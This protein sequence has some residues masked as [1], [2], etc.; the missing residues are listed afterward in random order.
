MVGISSSGDYI[1]MVHSRLIRNCPITP[2]AVN[3]ANT[4]FGPD[5]A[6][7]KGKTTRKYYKPV[8]TDHVEIP[9]HIL[10][11]ENAVTLEA[12]MMFVNGMGFFVGTSRKI[13]FTTHG[14]IPI[15]T[16]GKLGNSLRKVISLYNN[17]LFKIRNALMDREFNCLIPDFQ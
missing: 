15:C 5:I 8:V 1:N 17:S 3:I 14:Y 9:K 12:E 4:I 6:T 7:L 2:E 13:E 10:D 11:L 16:K